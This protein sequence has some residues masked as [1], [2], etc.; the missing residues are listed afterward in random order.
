MYTRRSLAKGAFVLPLVPTLWSLGSRAEDLGILEDDCG[1]ASGAPEEGSVLLWTRIPGRFRL[2]LNSQDSMP[3]RWEL[4]KEPGFNQQSIIAQGV[5]TTSA[6]S[7]WTVRVRARGL[8]PYTTYWYRFVT[9]SGYESV[10]GRTKTAP[11]AGMKI[12]RLRVALITCQSYS[13]G[14]Y[15]AFRHLALEDVDFCVHLGDHIY[16]IEKGSVRGHDPLQGR[17]ALSLHDYRLRYRQYLTDPMWREVRRLF[18]WIDLADDHEFVNDYAGHSDRAKLAERAAAAFQAFAEYNLVD[19]VLTRDPLGPVLPWYSRLSFGD[20]LEVFVCDERQ[21]RTPVPC[22]GSNYYTRGCE[23]MRAP[24]HTMLGPEQKRWLKEGLGSS[25]ASWKLMLNQVA[26]TPVRLPR[27]VKGGEQAALSAFGANLAE[28]GPSFLS[29]DQWDG[30]P[31]ERAELMQFAEDHVENLIIATGDIHAAGIARLYGDPEQRHGR[32][33]AIEVITTS[34][35][36]RTLG[37]LIGPWLGN[38]ANWLI[39]SL[40]PELDWQDLDRHGYAVLDFSEERLDIR[41]VAVD[42]VTKPVVAAKAV[43]LAAVT[44]GAATVEFRR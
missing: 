36:S 37:R 22:P 42:H 14:Y 39:R 4:A 5:V 2:G 15:A 25:R 26:M 31:E 30:Y 27:L 38:A 1:V 21:Y 6:A 33:S 9:D 35:T 28:K 7:D 23:A 19:A 11:A 17:E 8:A 41:H 34:I 10:V 29:L 44:S 12:D 20:L 18:P 3:V 24:Q 13:D 40:N 43:S 32:A 16:E